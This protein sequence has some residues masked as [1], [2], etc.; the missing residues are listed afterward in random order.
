M[1]ELVAPLQLQRRRLMLGFGG[2]SAAARDDGLER[3][4]AAAATKR[5]VY[6]TP[7]R[8][9]TLQTRLLSLEATK[10]GGSEARKREKLKH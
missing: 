6:K 1:I 7:I 10:T 9:T 2:G 5:R 8:R 4:A 3:A